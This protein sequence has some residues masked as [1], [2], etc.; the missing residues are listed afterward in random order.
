[1]RSAAVSTT[2]L[3]AAAPTRSSRP[4]TC[5]WTVRARSRCSSGCVSRARVRCAGTRIAWS[6]KP[7]SRSSS[8]TMR[9]PS[10]GRAREIGGEWT[11]RLAELPATLAFGDGEDGLLVC[12]ANPKSDDEHVWPDAC[13]DDAR[14]PVRRRVAAHDRVRPPAPAVRAR[15]ARA[16][17]RQRRVGRPAEGR[18]RARALRDPHAASGR[19]GSAVAPRPVRRREGRTPTARERHPRR[20]RSGSRRCAAID[21]RSS[22][23]P[24]R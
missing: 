13:D 21:T 17:A 20:A 10:R 7:N 2:R 1:M 8:R 6:A 14:A 3:R 19:L 9:E 11:R 23:R 24:A 16:N 22:A 4:A 15:V 5:A 18:R 12:H